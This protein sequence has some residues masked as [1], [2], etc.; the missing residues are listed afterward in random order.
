MELTSTDASL[1]AT[2]ESPCREPK[3]SSP[4]EPEAI[5]RAADIRRLIQRRTG[6]Q[7]RDL[8]V[9]VTSAGILLTGLCDTFYCK[10]LAQHAA[11]DH[12]DTQPLLNQIEVRRK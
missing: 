2:I 10:Q 12:D 1:A 9:Q 11:M 4:T 6:R 5:R 8:K 7:I 3:K